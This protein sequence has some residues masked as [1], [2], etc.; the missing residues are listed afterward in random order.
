MDEKAE[1]DWTS[2]CERVLA[3]GQG[4]PPK[5]PREVKEVRQRDELRRE[6]LQVCLSPLHWYSVDLPTADQDEDGR[7]VERTERKHFQVL[8][9][10]HPQSRPH[11]MP[12]IESHH[13]IVS[14]SA[15]GLH[16]QEASV[17]KGPASALSADVVDNA[18]VVYLDEDPRW[19]DWKDLGPYDHIFD[20]IMRFSSSRGVEEEPGCLALCN[21]VSAHPTFVLTD[22]RCPTLCIVAELLSRG[23]KTVPTTVFHSSKNLKARAM[24]G[25][26]AKRMK[27]YYIVLLDLE[28]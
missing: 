7:P 12:T 10:V 20:S 3:P 14:S 18:V 9:V 15:L 21:P 26:E 24:D 5:L 11:V 17:H 4:P 23:W 19:I 25:R 28:K 16:V 2:I 1:E 8:A 6:W 27:M 22:P 13:D